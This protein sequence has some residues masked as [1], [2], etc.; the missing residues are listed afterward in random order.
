MFNERDIESV[1][2]RADITDVVQRR[3]G[4]L[5]HGKACC[6]F[7]KEKTPSFHVNARTQSWHCFGGC[8]QGDNGGDAI[9]FVMKYDHLSFPEAVKTLAKEYGVR[10]EEHNEPRT[11]EEIAQDKKREAMRMLNEWACQFY[12]EAIHADND[13]AKFAYKYATES[14]GWGV[15][16][17]EENRIG[18]ADAANDSLYQAARTAGHSIDLMIEMGL[19]NKN[20]RGEIYDFYRNRLMI[21]I[22]D[23]FRHVI[24]F[25]ARDLT[26]TSKA[27]YMNSKDSDLYH[28]KGTIFGIDNAI[29]QARK[30]DIFYLVEGAP[31]AIKLQ[32]IGITN[33]VAPLGGAWQAEQFALLKPHAH[34]VCFIP[35]ADPA[36]PGEKM[37]AG[38]KFVCTNG[39]TALKAG[40]GVIV[41]EIPLTEDG[42]K[43]DPDSFINS[44]AAL[45]A[46]ES[47]DF[48]NSCRSWPTSMMMSRS[49]CCSSSCRSSTQTR[50]CG[51][52]HS[53]RREKP[54]RRRRYHPGKGR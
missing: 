24:G 8:P 38:K 31:D 26:G 54:T 32:A 39:L 23:R 17:V 43:Q 52:R 33:T 40:L 15:T 30:E 21:P 48:M 10:I 41:K 53:P 50:R 25:T 5:S 1:L 2:N 13:K 46:I 49:R 9:A 51:S 4:Q 29:S 44:P 16:Y 11:A 45:E 12:V 14:R 19:L 3:I 27:K 28:K 42:E 22:K 34:R 18:F 6:P 20:D 37:G 35:D 7:H 36:K 47:Q